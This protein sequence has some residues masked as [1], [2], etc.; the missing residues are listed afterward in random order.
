[1]RRRSCAPDCTGVHRRNAV[2]AAISCAVWGLTLSTEGSV[3]GQCSCLAQP[4]RGGKCVTKVSQAWGGVV[5]F[6]MPFEFETHNQRGGLSQ[7]SRAALAGSTHTAPC[8]CPHVKATNPT[9][10]RAFL[11]RGVDDVSSNFTQV[12][13]DKDV[14]MLGDLLVRACQGISTRRP[15]L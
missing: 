10:H 5:G 4:K 3:R 9:W 14:K 8:G 7:L 15:S 6:H 1:M 2:Q 11:H 13:K 12:R